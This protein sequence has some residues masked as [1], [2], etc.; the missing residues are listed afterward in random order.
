MNKTAE[1]AAFSAQIASNSYQMT[2]G[3]L[4]REQVLLGPG[5]PALENNGQVWSYAE[6]NDRVNRLVQVLVGYGIGR[7]DRVAMLSEN[8]HEYVEI[9]LAA[10]KLGVL[11]ACQNW[12]QADGELA[13]CLT[14]IEPKL[15][16]YSDRLAET[17]ERLD[18]E[19]PARLALGADYERAL[20]RAD[21]AEPPE[22][23]EAEDGLVVVYTSG[24]TGLPKAA[25]IS[26]RAEIMRAMLQRIEPAPIA[27]D[28]GFIAWSPMFHLSG[29]DHTIAALLRGAKVIVMDGFDAVKICEVASR[30][31]IGHLT[32]LPGVVDR[33][34]EALKSTGLRPLSVRTVGVV[35]DLVPPTS[36]AALT[37][38]VNAPYCNSFGTTE[39]GWPPASKSLIPIG[40]VPTR[41]S[42]EQSSYGI[43]KLVDEDDNVVPE[44]EAGEVCYRG[45]TM[46]SGYWRAPEVNAQVLRGGW[47]H[48][49]DV[50]RRNPDGTLDF[51]DRR[52]YLIKS[53]GENIYPAEIERILIA[54]PDV[55]DVVVVRKPD[56][57][58]GE[59]PVAFVVPRDGCTL[60]EEQAIA[61]CQGQIARYKIPKEIR[62]IAETDLRRSASGK[63]IRG[64]LE[65]VL[66]QEMAASALGE[67]RS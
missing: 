59:V 64:D 41:L 65:I 3:L 58:W 22:I 32:V 23:A 27:P 67:A 1:G 7:G 16:I 12:R 30:E 5:R 31:K 63:I 60:T 62:F 48:T 53:G 26:Q 49:G 36:I 33:M 43:I 42:K 56:A 35:S 4:F 20:D 2:V 40:V 25:V 14:L 44:G 37:E 29:T 38:L 61:A 54:L 51:V 50:M 28:D 34:V 15:V 39:C 9:L 6:L 66:K 46:F 57:K 10:A 8:R 45:P 55:A 47:Y 11:V 19:I 24:T 52:K 18:V 17:L 21:N 13:H